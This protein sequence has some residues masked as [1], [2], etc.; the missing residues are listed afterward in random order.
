[1][2]FED[3]HRKR[4]EMGEDAWENY[5]EERMMEEDAWY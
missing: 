2:Y 4:K 3:Q 5:M 1:M